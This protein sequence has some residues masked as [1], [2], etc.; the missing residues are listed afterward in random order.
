MIKSDYILTTMQITWY[1]QSLFQIL[2]AADKNG[3]IKIVIDPFSDSIGLRVPQLEADVLLLSH[4]HQDH[5]NVR[6]VSGN[7]FLVEEPGEYEVKNVF[8]Q[9][10]PSSHNNAS[11]KERG[12]NTIY[13]IQA[14][15]LRICHLG[16]LGQNELTD[17]QLDKIGDVDILMIPIGG[18]PTISTK[19]AQ[20]IMAQVEPKIT[21][22]MHYALPKL[23]I[24]LDPV[25][26]FLKALGIRSLEPM[27]KL[28]I[29]KKDIAPEE[30]KI[31]VLKP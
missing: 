9:G 18:G 19:E 28:S 10:V 12:G 21:I 7:Y 22:P 27:K 24:K 16:D 3:Q 6:L 13:I 2:S 30:A 4:Q 1:G 26:K 20:K 23:K 11:D 17:E 31:F 14:E 25:E 15:G 29:K 8:I 5:N